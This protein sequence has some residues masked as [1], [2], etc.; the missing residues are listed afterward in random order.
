VRTTVFDEPVNCLSLQRISSGHGPQ[1]WLATEAVHV[2]RQQDLQQFVRTIATFGLAKQRK[3]S[4]H[5]K[6]R[7]P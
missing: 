4:G 3:M 6:H 7:C 1:L 2:D 5:E